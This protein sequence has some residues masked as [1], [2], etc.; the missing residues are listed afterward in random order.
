MDLFGPVKVMSRKK[1]RYCLVIVDDFSRFTWTYF[2]HSKDETAGILQDFVKQVEKQFDLP[3]KVFR[4][5][6]GTEFRNRELDEFCVS[7]GIVRQYSIPRTLEQ[8]G[9]VERKNRILIEAVRTMLVDSG[10]PLTFWAEAVNTAC[11]VQNR[12]LVNPRHQKTAY[13]LLYKI[14]ALISYFKVFGCPCFI[15]NL[16]DSISKFAA[17]VD[18]GYHLGYSTF[19]KAYKVFNT[20]SKTVEETLNVKF[21]ELSSMK[22]PTNPTEL[23]DLDKFT[24]ENV[25]VKTNITGPS[26]NPPSDNGYEVI[27]PLQT[28]KSIARAA[29]VQNSCQSSTT[30]TSTLVDQSSPLTP[31]STSSNIVDKSPQTVDKSQHVST[32]IPP[33]P[34]PP[35]QDTIRSSKS[36]T[37]V[38]SNDSHLQP[39][40]LNVIVPYKGD[41]IFLKSHPPDQ[42]IGNISEG[43]LTRSQS[44][45]ICL[46]AGFLPLHQPIK[47]QEAL[48][49]NSWIEATQEELQQ[50]KRQQAWELVPL[51]EGVSP[52]GRK[53][54]FKNKTDERGIVVKNKARLVVQGFRQ[55]EGIDYD[56]TFS[57]VARLDAIRLFLAFAVNHN[58]KVFQKDIKCA[59][60]YGKIQEEVYVCQPPGFEDPFYPNHVY[61]LNKALYGLKQAPRAWYETL[62]TFLLSIG[63][64]R[65]KIDKTLFL[66]WRGKELMIVQIYVDDIIFGS[67][68]S[69]MC[70]EFRQLMTAEFEMS[71]MGELQCFLG[72]LVKQLQNGTFIHQGKYAKELLTK[73]DMND[74]KPCSTPVATTKIVMS[75]EKDDLVDQPLYRSMIGSLLYLTA[76]RPDIM[77]AT[78]VCARSQ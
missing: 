45:N 31:A 74:C 13:E 44:Q 17:K 26:Q 22:I 52:I 78:C 47:Y 16:K 69:K 1:K 59:F 7:K 37:V 48:K 21:N 46:F 8:N 4:S 73:F 55:E 70:E 54:V 66:K 11:Y 51:P 10:L 38:S 65:G 28:L 77:F 40:P 63:F 58:I 6:N 12:V 29:D 50:F 72:L 18:S 36:P 15:L 43:V 61:K 39:L 56:E 34:P 35:F 57:P 14:K 60:L 27:L 23:F 9:V 76:S 75:D 3:V 62:S 2:L 64:T 53:W 20:R 30:A 24:F 25:S 19:A 41:L 68:C 33:I 71:V 42:I 67:A 49:D 32:T 5:E